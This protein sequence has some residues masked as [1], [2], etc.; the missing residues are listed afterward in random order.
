[1]FLFLEI[2]TNGYLKIQV[3]YN[4]REYLELVGE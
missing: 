3:M 2:R 1:M 4:I